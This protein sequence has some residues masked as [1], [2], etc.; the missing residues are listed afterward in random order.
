MAWSASQYLKFEEERT[1]PA[2]DLLAEIRHDAVTTA[3]DLGCGPGNS[4]ELLAE[5]FPGAAIRGVD[6]DADMLEAAR[7]R[8]PALSFEQAD[9]AAWSPAQPVDVLFAN[10]VLQWLPDHLDVMD[11][12]IDHLTPGGVLAVQMPDNLAEPSHKAMEATLHDG[13]WAAEFEGR[14]LRR[15]SLPQPIAYYERL[16]PKLAGLNLWHT[17]YRH[18]M[19]DA[20]AIVEWVKATGLRPYLDAVGDTYREKF[21]AAYQ[22]RIADAY[23]PQEDGKCLLL[24]PRFF[25]VAVKK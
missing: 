8:L 6:S 2:R 16:S 13:P 20:A 12:L 5:R 25:L 3:V 4:T 9:I 1:Q 14:S 11:R 17:V 21:L 15:P 24:F 10:A 7:K 18:P 19:D 23:P 22:A